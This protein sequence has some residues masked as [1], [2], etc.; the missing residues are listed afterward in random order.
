MQQY[1]AHKYRWKTR[2]IA[3]SFSLSIYQ[4]RY[5]LMHLY[6]DGKVLKEGAGR[7]GLVYWLLRSNTP[8]DIGDER[9][10]KS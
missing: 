5:Y 3:S 9:T 8:D 2:E 10:H 7:G 6:H 1:K 4:A